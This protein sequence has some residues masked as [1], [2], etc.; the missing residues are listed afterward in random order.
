MNL[1][2]VRLWLS[3]GSFDL[4]TTETTPQAYALLSAT[5][6]TKISRDAKFMILP[7][8]MSFLRLAGTRRAERMVEEDS[9]AP[10]GGDAS[11][12]TMTG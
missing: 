5:S 1:V 10:A 3:L 7:S 4:M 11:T 9:G 12:V 6:C 8:K 2:T